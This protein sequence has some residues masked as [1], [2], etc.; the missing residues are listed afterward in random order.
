MQGSRPEWQLGL[1]DGCYSTR[2]RATGLRAS[3]ER[4]C[5]SARW[6]DY[7]PNGSVAITRF[8]DDWTGRDEDN[9]PCHLL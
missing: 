9:V 5:K 1:R 8:T 4:T 7:R 3:P 6:A 2:M